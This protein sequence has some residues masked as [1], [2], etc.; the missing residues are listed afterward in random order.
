MPIWSFLVMGW[1]L[2]IW[3]PY[4][5]LPVLCLF[6]LLWALNIIPL[7]IFPCVMLIWSVLYRAAICDQHKFFLLWVFFHGCLLVSYTDLWGTMSIFCICIGFSLVKLILIFTIP[8]KWILKTKFNP[9]IYCWFVLVGIP[10]S[11]RSFFQVGCKDW[12]RRTSFLLFSSLVWIFCPFLWSI[13]EVNI[14]QCFVLL[15]ERFDSAFICSI[16]GFHNVGVLLYIFVFHLK[17]NVLAILY[18]EESSVSDR[19]L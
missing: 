6:D 4:C 3:Y 16:F 19:A 13:M 5:I 11:D 1:K 18:S 7:L 8:C 12:E 10:N 17:R 15:M 9:L 2:W 14:I